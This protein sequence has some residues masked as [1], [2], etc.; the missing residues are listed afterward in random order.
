MQ[1]DFWKTLVPNGST[2]RRYELL[3]EIATGGMATVY[4][5]LR[6]GHMG[7]ERLVALKRALPARPGFDPSTLL[8]QEAQ[9]ASRVHHPNVVSIVDMEEV[10]DV[11]LLVMD[12]VEGATLGQLM[13]IGPIPP[14]VLARILADV[15]EGL[16]AIHCTRGDDGQRLGIVHRDISPQNVLVGT[17]GIA[18]L[19]DFG[20]AICAS[21]SR[22][23]H[24]KARRGR[25][26]YMAPEYVTRGVATPSTDLYALSVVAWEALTGKRLFGSSE[27]LEKTLENHARYVPPPSSVLAQDLGHWDALVMRGLG[28]SAEPR[29]ETVG[30]LEIA[31]GGASQGGVGSRREIAEL[32]EERAARTLWLR[33]EIIRARMRASESS[34][35]DDPTCATGVRDAVSKPDSAGRGEQGV[36]SGRSTLRIPRSG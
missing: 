7:F 25:P 23:T 31:L 18:R 1:Q 24:V 19:A 26:G 12:Y 10:D 34:E 3:Q 14:R 28:R 2:S 15:S 27:S 11:P 30:Q 20:I 33:R 36:V 9:L 22:T 5:A 29:Y 13:E 32:V 6:R 21:S 16:G 4:L 17:D 35:A 8:R